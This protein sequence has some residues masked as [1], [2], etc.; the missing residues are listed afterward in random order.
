MKHKPKHIL[1]YIL[2]ILTIAQY[3]KS[4]IIGDTMAQAEE[5]PNEEDQISQAIHEEQQFEEQNGGGELTGVP[6]EMVEHDNEQNVDPHVQFD[7]ENPAENIAGEDEFMN[8]AELL[9]EAK[10]E[11]GDETEPETYIITL[12]HHNEM[13]RLRNF[14]AISQ[15]MKVFEE[16]YRSCL[17]KIPSLV[18]SEVEIEKCV[19][20][21]FTQIV[22]D[23]NFERAK[24]KD[25]AAIKLREIIIKD[26]YEKAGA[27][28][29]QSDA[30][31]LFERDLIKLLWDQM[32]IYKMMVFNRDKY[33]FVYGRMSAEIFDGMM[34]KIK[35][36]N[37][38]L[39]QLI[40]EI[41]A[42][43]DLVVVKIKE[44]VDDRTKAIVNL[45][46]YNK[47][48]GVSKIKSYDLHIT[49][50]IKDDGISVAHLPNNLRLDTNTDHVFGDSPY[51]DLDREI[52]NMKAAN[53]EGVYQDSK[54]ISYDKGDITPQQ[55]VI[56]Q[57]S[58]DEHT[59]PIKRKL[60]RVKS[61]LRRDQ[62]V[63]KMELNKIK[64]DLERKEYSSR[65]YRHQNLV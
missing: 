48:N 56:N 53:L 13:E 65:H 31:D 36:I 15:D 21:D 10:G 39:S 18:W 1:I 25:R 17:Q 59:V 34:K 62:E 20:P 12:N 55:F 33:M 29:I 54:Y 4:D 8:N 30:C 42:H 26:C 47:R 45:A 37:D 11:S 23:I 19:G 5:N 2:G 28:E 32:E 49:Q 51:T 44:L 22:N 14:K 9:N 50:T 35:P 63:R 7:P 38:E 43:R 61:N 24:I 64:H 3:T 52:E 57:I 6:D 40:D 16:G 27:D 58:G 41:E 60:H 46:N